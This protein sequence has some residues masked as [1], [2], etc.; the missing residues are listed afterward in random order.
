MKKLTVKQMQIAGRN[1][2]Y[3]VTQ[4]VNAI[5][6]KIGEVLSVQALDGYCKSP[7]FTVTIK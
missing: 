6:P 2:Q 5:I 1:Y 4:V 7:V 3:K